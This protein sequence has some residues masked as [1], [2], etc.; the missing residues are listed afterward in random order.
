MGKR[1]DSGGSTE[2]VP[3]IFVRGSVVLDCSM[4]MPLCR[5][6]TLLLLFLVDST[7]LIR[8]MIGNMDVDADGEVNKD[9]AMEYFKL[10]TPQV[11]RWFCL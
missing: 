2:P 8:S 7:E 11:P 5:S 1:V 4:A 3:G 9:E 6:R 10:F